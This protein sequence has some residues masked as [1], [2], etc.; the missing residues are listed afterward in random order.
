MTNEEEEENIIPH[1]T[2]KVSIRIWTNNYTEKKKNFLK[3]SIT[4]NNHQ[5]SLY[6]HYIPEEVPIC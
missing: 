2:R 3:K 6:K 4:V 1:E 5:I